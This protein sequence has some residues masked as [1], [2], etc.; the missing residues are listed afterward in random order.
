MKEFLLFFSWLVCVFYLISFGYYLS[1][2]KEKEERLAFQIRLWL[3]VAALSHSI[4]LVFLG[5]RLGHLPVGDVYQ[6]LTTCAWLFVLVY[7]F[8]EIRLK[9][10]TLGVFF[11]PIIVILQAIS[12]FLIDVD[13]ALAPVLTDMIFE[14]HVAIMISAY[15]AFAISFISSLM[16]ILLS[17]EMQSKHLGIFFERLPSLEFFDKLSNQ[18]VNIGLVLVTSGIL[19]GFYMGINVWEGSWPLD[20]KLLA[21][22]IS[23]AIYFIH[24]VTRK[25]IGWQGRRAAIVSVI[26]FNWLLFSFIIVSLFWS[27]F[28][29]FR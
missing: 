17:R 2:F 26:G 10:M 3:I 5:F 23:W 27:K 4:Y 1:Y 7:L 15:A 20:P 9:E 11:L 25:S 18:A 19:L 28:H 13:K 29:N 6:A 8:L 21:V 12:N 14:V 24:F 16:Y 22:V